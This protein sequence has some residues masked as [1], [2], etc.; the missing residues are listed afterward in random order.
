MLFPVSD[1]PHP[2]T[3]ALAPAPY[4]RSSLSGAQSLWMVSWVV[5]PYAK[6]RHLR[7]G[8][9]PISEPVCDKE[10]SLFKDTMHRDSSGLGA[11]V[12]A[13]GGST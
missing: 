4:S 11:T 5:L 8:S 1:L 3:L 7:T 6:A 13:P 9:T 2:L 10:C 12:S